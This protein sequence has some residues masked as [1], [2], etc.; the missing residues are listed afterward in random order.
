MQA[1]I[2]NRYLNASICDV[3]PWYYLICCSEMQVGKRVD[4]AQVDDAVGQNTA[5]KAAR[6]DQRWIPEDH[7]LGSM[8]LIMGQRG[9]TLVELVIVILILGI[10]AATVVPKVINNAAEAT[11]NGVKQTLWAVR[12]AIDMYRALNGGALPGADK[13][14]A[15]F[16]R[17]LAKYL[18]GSFPTCPVGVTKNNHVLIVNV[19]EPIDATTSSPMSWIYSAT[20]GQFIINYNG[21]T[22]SDPTV[23]YDEL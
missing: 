14:E 10:L 12:D 19:A 2:E 15:T 20:T 5:R 9:F 7:L 3:A 21:R 8:L 4:A 23:S 18:R 11:D 22:V 1:C 6:R 16:K 17:E 13:E